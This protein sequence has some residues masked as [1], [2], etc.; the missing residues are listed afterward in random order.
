VTLKV[1]G[2]LGELTEQVSIRMPT[3]RRVNKM[4]FLDP[5][6]VRDKEIVNVLMNKIRSIWSHDLRKAEGEA[7]EKSS[8]AHEE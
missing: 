1:E 7:E 8:R 5:R 6:E 4:E 3:T 2:A